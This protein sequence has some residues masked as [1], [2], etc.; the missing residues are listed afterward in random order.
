MREVKKNFKSIVDP[1]APTPP[2]QKRF[3]PPS[4]EDVTSYCNERR[5]TVDP[6]SFMAF[7]E[8]NGWKVGKN[9]MKDWKAAVRTWEG[10][11]NRGPPGKKQGG[12]WVN[13][14]AEIAKE[15]RDEQERNGGTDSNHGRSL[16]LNLA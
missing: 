9:P 6:T 4:V 15:L 13:H 8:S 10:R 1:A 16:P 12:G 14:Y 3:S 2:S 11:E 5:N 7:Y